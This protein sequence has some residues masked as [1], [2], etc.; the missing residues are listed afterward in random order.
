MGWFSKKEY[1]G[2]SRYPLWKKGGLCD[3]CN[4]PL[5]NETAY[6]VPCKDFWE[7]TLYCERTIQRRY[8]EAK[9]NPVLADISDEDLRQFA[10]SSYREQASKD[11]T[12]SAVCKDCI[13]MFE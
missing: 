9:T 10:I 8:F 12:P 4:K 6:V 1:D 7:S 3:V 2:Y 5:D 13:Y 11:K